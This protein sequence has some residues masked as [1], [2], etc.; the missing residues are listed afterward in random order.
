[1]NKQH[2]VIFFILFIIGCTSYESTKT[3]PEYK[4]IRSVPFES[5]LAA[6][7]W[8]QI[9]NPFVTPSKAD[10]ESIILQDSAVEKYPLE[11]NIVAFG[12]FCMKD[13]ENV[14]LD[15]LSS[16]KSAILETNSQSFGWGQYFVILSK[17]VSEDKKFIVKFSI[18]NEYVEKIVSLHN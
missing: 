9:V 14:R 6:G 7:R 12:F 15:I 18:G 13:I 17:I 5:K 1:M 3:T 4:V 8:E 2:F 11:P 16:D 10:D